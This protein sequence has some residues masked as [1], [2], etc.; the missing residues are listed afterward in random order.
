MR[1]SLCLALLLAATPSSPTFAGNNDGQLD[2]TFGGSGSVTWYDGGAVTVADLATS[3]TGAYAVGTITLVGE[4]PALHFKGFNHGGGELDQGCAQTSGTLI[5]FATESN[6]LAGLIDSSGN[7]LVGGWAAFLGTETTHR[8]LVS[9][10]DLSGPGCVLDDSFSGNGWA[11]FDDETFCDTEDCD[12][13]DLVEIRP[14]TGA[15]LAP[16]IIA[17]VRS[18]L[19]LLAAPRLF[20]LALTGSGAIDTGFDGNGWTEVTEPGIG[21][22]YSRASLALDAVGRI[23]VFG[24]RWDPAGTDDVD[25]VLFR[26][27]PNG[28]HDVSF[29]NTGNGAQLYGAGSDTE[30]ALPRGVAIDADGFSVSVSQKDAIESVIVTY[31]SET[32]GGGVPFNQ[33]VA[34]V[35]TQGNGRAVEV[36]EHSDGADGFE[37][38]RYTI[39]PQGELQTDESFGGLGGAHNYDLDLGGSNSETAAAVAIWNGRALVAGTATATI[40][41]AGFLLRTRNAYIF[42]D[43]FEQG[44]VAY[45][46]S[47]AGLDFPD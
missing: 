18:K 27:L 16:R 36:G 6:G 17:L 20:L 38:G 42:A 7:I 45:W 31:R 21:E 14:A 29:G 37:L 34:A 4:E 8:A 2:N 25:T 12:V 28:A 3:S 26:F 32:E 40:G 44:T 11:I 23:Y 46:S 35:A 9:R 5:N 1:R 39:G 22:I 10:F 30:D 41:T 47:A 13:L 19:N 24:A 15:V 33:V 43:G